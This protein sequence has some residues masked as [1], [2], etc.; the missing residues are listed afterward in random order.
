MTGKPIYKFQSILYSDFNVME[1]GRLFCVLFLLGQ[2]SVSVL[3]T[4]SAVLSLILNQ[5]G[6][7]VRQ[8]PLP[9]VRQRRDNNYSV[10]TV[11]LVMSRVNVALLGNF[12]DFFFFIEDDSY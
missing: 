9:E 12:M 8:Y 10:K 1:N 11:V 2:S 3:L 7:Y 4:L 6:P 5:Q